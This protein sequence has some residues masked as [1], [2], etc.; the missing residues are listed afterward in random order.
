MLIIP[1]V[2]IKKGQCVSLTNDDIGASKVYSDDVADVVG[3]WFD[4]G[5]KRLHIV[6]LDGA[7]EG[8]SVNA[9]LICQVAFRFPN[10]EI[11]VSGGI[12]TLAEIETYFNAGVNFVAL[13]AKAFLDP[14]FVIKA[15]EV[16]PQRIMV[17]IDAKD[18]KLMLEARTKLSELDAINFA[19]QFDQPGIAGLIYSEVSECSQGINIDSVAKLAALMTVPVIASGGIEDIDDIR[20]LY[21]ESHKGIRGAMSASALQMGNLDLIEAQTYCDEFED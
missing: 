9:E 7:L 21:A 18:S 8:C 2:N 13:G 4:K 11:Q 6:D 16:F 20:A 1:V 14:E 17:S 5:A 15:S 19:H 3:R 12:R 10:L